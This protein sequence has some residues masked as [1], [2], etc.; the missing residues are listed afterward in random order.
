MVSTTEQPVWPP[1][2]ERA[3]VYALVL[4]NLCVTLPLAYKLNIW[5]DEAYTL[6]TTAGGVADA[7][8]R[9]ISFELQP[10]LYFVLS[11]LWRKVSGSVFCARLFSVVCVAL[12]VRVAAALSR[13]YVPRIH[14]GWLAAVV[15]LHPFAV[16]AATEIRVYALVV[17][18]SALLLLL[19]F[20]GYL[21]PEPRRRARVLY[22]LLC[23]LALYTHYYLG[24]IL[25]A[26]ACALLVL[27]RWRVLRAYLVGMAAVALCF[28][29][30]ALVVRGQMGVLG[31]SAGRALTPA[32][33]L[34]LLYWRVYEYALPVEW[35]PS[36]ALRSWLVRLGFVAALA[37][38]VAWLRRRPEPAHAA[39]LII[40]TTAAFLFLIPLLSTG[41]AFAHAR[42]TTALF[43]PVSL[44]L[45]AVLAS[46]GRKTLLVAWILVS[47]SF[48]A[49]SLATT[50]A[51]LAKPGD[52]ERVAAYIRAHE[53]P[54]QPVLVFRA[55]G[56]LPLAHYYSG[57]NPLVPLPAPPDLKTYDLRAET[58]GGEA[59]I[60]AALARL[61][62]DHERL[63]LVTQTPCEYLDLDF[64]CAALESFV[65]RNYAVES[66]RSFV[67]ADVR[68]LRKS[69]EREMGDGETG[70]QAGE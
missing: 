13:R 10:P 56:A 49:G 57:P 37:T 30:L 46:F 47:L 45:L 22:V 44:S 9:A 29:P 2:S 28:A 6:H 65:N 27:R 67:N 68:L 63:W 60:A 7:W 21:A 14:A 15:A 54:G 23:V 24:F 62:G 40:T 51:P 52:W 16:W 35:V 69:G 20:D 70:R 48:Y 26:N 8:R 59:D 12:T 32:E 39:A 42:H 11:S 31:N 64:N 1:V 5:T 34:K 3:V 38:L 33:A 41:E 4:V 17:L 36:Q 50:Y 58:I 19:F 43:V 18:L 25:A 53:Q 55:S 66:A 61:G